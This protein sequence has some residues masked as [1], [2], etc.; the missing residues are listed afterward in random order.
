MRVVAFPS[1]VGLEVM[2]KFSISHASKLF[3]STGVAQ[4]L[5]D[6]L[7]FIN[8]DNGDMDMEH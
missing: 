5:I 7:F 2:K 1:K 4:R 6:T 8:A 3:A